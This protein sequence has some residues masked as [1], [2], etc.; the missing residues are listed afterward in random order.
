VVEGREKVPAPPTVIYRMPHPVITYPP[1]PP[2]KKPAWTVALRH[3]SDKHRL[4]MKCADGTCTCCVR[5]EAQIKG[6]GKLCFAAGKKYVHVSG[7]LWKACADK[8]EMPGDGTLV[9]CG[10]VK[11]LSDKVGACA[12]LKAEHVTVCLKKDGCVEAIHV[13]GR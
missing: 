12:S 8:V 3:D 6:M 1:Q 2:E 10:H 7:R 11:V 13:M 4:Q 9:L 5:E